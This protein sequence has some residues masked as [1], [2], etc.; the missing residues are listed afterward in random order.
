MKSTKF[1][2]LFAVLLFAVFAYR[3]YE[4]YREIGKTEE[5]IVLHESSSL[6]K[7]ISS[8]R[9]TY[10]DVFLREHIKIDDSSLN[11]L[12]VKTIGEISERFGSKIN[13]EI[14][15]RTVSD[16]PRNPLNKA[17]HFETEMIDYFKS[18]PGEKYKFVENEGVYNYIRPLYIEK[19]CLRCHGKREEAI[20]SVQKR[21][22]K[23]YDYKLGEVRGVMHIEIKDHDLFAGLYDNFLSSLLATILIYLLLLVIIYLL[24][25]RIRHKEEEYLEN[26]EEDIEKKTR[27]INKQKETFKTLF[28][29]SSD[30]ILIVEGSR[31]IECNE[32][33]VEILK[34]K[35]KEE[36]LNIHY[37][38]MVPEFQPDGSNSYEKS[39]EMIALAEE[40]KGYQF[41]CV[42]TRADGEEFLA[43]VTLT[44]IVLDKRHVIYTAVRDISDKKKAQ[45]ELLE[46]K[47][48]LHHQAHHDALTGLPNRTLFN[49]RLEHGLKLAER[50][51][52]KL[53]LLF[54]DLDN[55][56]QINDS[57]GHQIGDRVLV[58]VSERL[59]AKIRKEDTLARLGGDEFTVIMENLHEI[60]HVSVL[61]Q[62]IQDVLTQPM[63]IEGHTLYISCSIGISFYPQDAQNANDLVKY[64]D[65]AMY[66][67]KEEGRN[68]FQ[69]YSA[70]MTTLAYERVMMIANLRQAI[71]NEEFTLYYQPQVNAQSSKM[72]GLEALIRWEHPDQGM[73]LPN[74]FI[75]V[76][77]ESGL[78]LEIDRWVMHTAMAQVRKWYDQGFDPGVLSL[79]LSIR[80]LKDKSFLETIRK[81][82]E[83]MSF[84]PEWLEL[85]V[86]EG[87][88]MKKPDEAVA[89]LEEIKSMGVSIAIDDFGTGYSSLSYLKRLPVGKLKIDQSFIRGIPGDKENAAIVKATIALAK[90]LNLNI[91]AEGVESREQKEFLVHNGCV[92]MQG[93]YYSRPM[94]ADQIEKKCFD[95]C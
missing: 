36:L 33:M 52:S 19:S 48:I 60:Q 31:F 26:L 18:H 53:A 38:S 28:E 29:K 42:Y 23:A 54:I 65:A 21:Y 35:S 95:A 46:Q 64:A 5:L 83:S 34:Y 1:F 76:A 45:M 58:S 4:Q 7:F 12:P 3:T 69:F 24:I 51:K 94:P 20:L 37:T 59:K 15:I 47:N 87:Q 78:I 10:Q 43:E 16:R 27:E 82:L 85:E 93:Y 22:D 32:K 56:K 72:V 70:E 67:A 90:S 13:G 68:N 80:Q 30:G 44:P 50:Q 81:C 2:V 61:A 75:P 92:A 6:A 86:T 57:L 39:R 89:I 79:N 91:I 66:K 55:F 41:E 49:D 9:Q 74:T 77:E 14:V 84:E 71:R 40:Y 11:L 25:K 8:F 17:D 62:K 73:I 88:M 63:H